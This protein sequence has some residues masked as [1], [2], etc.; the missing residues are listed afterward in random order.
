MCESG[1]ASGNGRS[2]SGKWRLSKLEMD[3][4]LASRCFYLARALALLHKTTPL[5]PSYPLPSIVS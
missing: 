1:T 3:A 2:R 4:C 5:S